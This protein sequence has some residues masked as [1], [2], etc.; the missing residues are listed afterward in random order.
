[1]ELAL[2][3]GVFGVPE[4]CEDAVSHEDAEAVHQCQLQADV[5]EV[6]VGPGQ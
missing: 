3:G 6:V 5:V 4:R 2:V 1:M